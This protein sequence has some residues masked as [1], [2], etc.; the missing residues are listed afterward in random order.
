LLARDFFVFGKRIK[1]F[2]I[3]YLL[4]Y[5]V[6][7]II[8]FGYIQPGIYFG[9]GHTKTSVVLLIGTFCINMLSLCYTL[10][11]PF[12]FD[13]ESDRFI[14]YQITVVP[15]R[16][17]LIKMILFPAII[18]MIISLP[19]FPLAY[20]LLPG[21]FAA[22]NIN[23]FGLLSVVVAAAFY[24]ASYIMMGL[25]MIK[26]ASRIRQFWLRFNWPLVV[27]GG[28]WIPFYLLKAHFPILATIALFDPFTYFTEGIRSA[29]I[30]SD[31]FIPY[32]V[33]IMA[34]FCFFCMFSMV[35]IYFFEHKVDHV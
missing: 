22:L 28:L 26:R 20:I 27:L 3:N 11:A 15:P 24:C 9:P 14:D 25:C 5:P 19:F 33:C 13:L 2:G 32:H 12:V 31:Q 29:L 16:L 21:Y 18:A 34:L 1:S 8:T 35:S 30:G 6:L 7:A 4:I 23:W 10:M 17:L